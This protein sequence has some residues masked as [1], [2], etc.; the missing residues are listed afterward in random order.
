MKTKNN[1]VNH[2]YTGCVISFLC[3]LFVFFTSCS[4]KKEA[5]IKV[6]GKEFT[7]E[8]LIKYFQKTNADTSVKKAAAIS[9]LI[10]ETILDEE[11]KK[12]GV[13]LSKEEIDNFL[14]D[15]NI[16]EQNVHIAKLYLLRQKVAAMLVKDLSPT[17]EMVENIANE[18]KDVISEKYVFQQVLVNKEE[19]A[20]KV[21]DEIK[22]GLSFEDAAK[23]Y[24]ISPEGKRGGLIDYLNADELPTELLNV[25]KKLKAGEMSGVVSSPFG[26]HI[27]KLK[28][29][30]RAKKLTNEEKEASATEEAKKRLA[31][32]NYADWFAKKR[33]EYN[34]TVKWEEI[35]KL[36]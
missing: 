18:M 13:S 26:F 20:Y 1:L 9:K 35:E 34:V 24:S 2:S 15:S 5:L 10:E 3:I 8:D 4:Q 27:L 25:L 7:K 16:K 11:A 31:G 33:K 19:T 32:D 36:Q 30:I 21:L 17:K 23:N 29:V 6:G 12:L 22:K 28:E 14:K